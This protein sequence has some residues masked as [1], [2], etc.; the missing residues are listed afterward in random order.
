MSEKAPSTKTRP[1]K[2][3]ET[4]FFEEGKRLFVEGKLEE[5]ID[6]FTKA[7]EA[8]YDA[9]ISFLSRGTAHLR[10]KDA[11]K[12]LKDFTK[13]IEIDKGYARA[14]YY[15]GMALYPEKR[16]CEGCS[17]LQQGDRSETR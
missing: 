17:R 3:A 2:A 13:T 7:M 10:L 5:S 6:T 11:D 15:R 4:D 1:K 9:K 14:Y 12:A 16:F 8:G